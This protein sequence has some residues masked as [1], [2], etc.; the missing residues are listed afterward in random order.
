MDG[1]ELLDHIRLDARTR[2]IP[3]IIITSKDLSTAE[4]E[5]LQ[6]RISALLTKGDIDADRVL[7]ELSTLLKGI[8]GTRYFP[9]GKKPRILLVD[10]NEIVILQVRSVLEPAGYQVDVSNGGEEALEYTKSHVPD[11]I[12]LDLMMPKVDGFM[13]LE[14]IRGTETTREIPVLILT[15]KNLTREELA[16]LSGNNVK[17]L[18][19]KGDV[20]RQE[21]LLK[22]ELMLNQTDPVDGPSAKSETSV[23]A[24]PIKPSP[25][26][27]R[28]DQAQTILLIEDNPDNVVTVKAVLGKSYQ[29]IDAADGLIALDIL[30]K[31]NPCLILLDMGLPKMD[32]L[33]VLKRIRE[34]PDMNHIPVIALTAH[35]MKDD[36]E[37]YLRAGCSDYISKPFDPDLLVDK[38]N[39]WCK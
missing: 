32:G 34:N 36:R 27:L 1:F 30:E 12:I 11:G 3:V 17:Q 31:V 26:N 20:D 14:S 4:K 21:L 23:P 2:H 5:T 9:A 7:Q 22:V 24:E 16:R 28:S 10:D 15:A 35:A 29:V 8:E 33:T 18:L 39:E 6:G 38:V 25:V 37:R 19:H 13:V